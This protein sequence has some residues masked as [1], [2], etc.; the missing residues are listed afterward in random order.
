MYSR[1]IVEL[2]D[3]IR[4]QEMTLGPDHPDLADSVVRLA[5]LCFIFNRYAQAESLYWK[6]VTIRSRVFG[7]EHLSVSGLLTDLGLLYQ[8]QLQYA[9][10]EHVFRLAYA[11]KAANFGSSHDEALGAARNVVAVCRAQQKHISETELERMA[12][13]AI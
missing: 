4:K 6:A 11:I 5:H 12:R 8:I 7:H 13:V 2:E 9:E 1:N 10:A 3:K